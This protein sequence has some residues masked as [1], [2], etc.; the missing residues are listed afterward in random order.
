MG[1]AHDRGQKHIQ[2]GNPL[3]KRKFGRA[4]HMPEDIIKMDL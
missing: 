3:W 1:G 2:N 4:C